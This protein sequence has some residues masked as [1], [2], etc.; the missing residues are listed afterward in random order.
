MKLQAVITIAKKC[1]I[2]WRSLIQRTYPS[3]TINIMKLR[4]I[5]FA[6]C[7]IFLSAC[8]SSR[9]TTG[10]QADAVQISI[11]LANVRNDQVRVNVVPP[12]SSSS[13]ATYQL[14]KII[15]GTYAIADYGRY[16][17][18]FQALDGSGNSLP[19]SRTD[20]NT[21][22]IS[23]ANKLKKITY[24]VNDTYDS[25]MGDAFD[26]S[27]H[28]IFSP[29]GTNI[30]AGKNFVL[31]MCG[32]AGYFSG[33][34]DVPYKITISHPENLQAASSLKDGNVSKTIDDFTVSRYAEMVDNPIMYSEPDIASTNING[35]EVLL[36]VYSPRR[37]SVTAS[38]LF[39]DL[40]KMMRAQKAYLGN[41]NH[42]PRYAVLNYVTSY[43]A[44]DARGIGA[45]EHNTSTT[46]VFQES[47]RSKD[48]IHVISHEFFHT[49]TPLNV[50]SREIQDF[51]FNNP[52]MSQHLWMYE[53]F[54][55][56]FAN[57]FQVHQG[58]MTEEQFLAK[59]A[60]KE[61]FSKQMY[62]DDQS[63]TE[64]SKNV[65]EPGMKA[66]YPNVYQKGAL[67]AMC[68][69]IMLREASGGKKGILNMMGELS[70]KYG[71][72]KP[73]DDNSIISEIT[74]MTNP[75]VGAFLQEHVVK[76]TPIDYAKYLKRVGI[77][78][79][80]VKEPTPI[81]FLAN[82]RPYLMV[83]TVNKKAIAIIRDNGNNFMN[84]LGVQNGDEIIEM[85]ESPLDASTPMNVMIAGYG[86]EEDEPVTMKVKR[87][88]QIVELKGKAKLNYVDGSGFKFVDPSK[89]K[90]KNAWLRE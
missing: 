47:M 25:E 69:D 11:D 42:T 40:E 84:A 68:I 55:E 89:E 17:V 16:V 4:S 39:P 73:F 5:F 62:K 58:L 50:H 53:G 65:L 24:L 1:D 26:E 27:S 36:S 33:K 82:N 78:R 10:S 14:A 8:S 41:I 23:Q 37:K 57:H 15:P 20:S 19:I 18:D 71:P 70:K 7:I 52:K 79:A 12:P 2:G 54:T 67:I 46:A 35:M 60:E 64:M 80:I 48:L 44:D 38:S 21:W 61:K 88:G 45:L 86:M 63:F 29:A 66:Q 74:Q 81:V 77:D 32:F 3:K 9:R 28:T 56:Y 22:V 59:M 75:E 83:D 6:A 49:L 87:N 72:D 43:M 30:L 90:L 76:G 31:N 85:N 51:D 34:K 13:T